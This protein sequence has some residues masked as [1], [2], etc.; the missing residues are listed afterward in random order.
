MY[1]TVFTIK[2]NNAWTCHTAAHAYCKQ[3]VSVSYSCACLLQ[4]M[5]RRVIQVAVRAHYRHPA[6]N[7]KQD[8]HTTCTYSQHL[9]R[10]CPSIHSQRRLT[11]REQRKGRTR[12]VGI[13]I[14]RETRL[15]FILPGSL[16]VVRNLREERLGNHREPAQRAKCNNMTSVNVKMLNRKLTP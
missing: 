2:F 9:H 15:L 14:S 7:R 3:S 5:G 6:R 16:P 1:C 11:S 4:T 10:K 12:K 13:Q 8:T